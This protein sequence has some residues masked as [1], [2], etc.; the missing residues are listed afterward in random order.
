VLKCARLDVRKKS[1]GNKKLSTKGSSLTYE[2]MEMSMANVME[3]YTTINTWSVS[4]WL[5]YGDVPKEFKHLPNAI[6]A[7]EIM[8]SPLYVAMSEEEE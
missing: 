5:N 8:E 1:V 7:L 3:D 6:K 4:S 2:I